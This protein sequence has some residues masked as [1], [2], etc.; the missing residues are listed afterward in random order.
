MGGRVRP[1]RHPDPLKADNQKNMSKKNDIIDKLNAAKIEFDPEASVKELEA[2]LPSDSEESTTET[3]GDIE[4][5]DPMLLRPR[6]LPLVVKPAD[7]GEWK[8]PEQA[9]YARYLNA[10]AYKNP[11]KW[12]L[13]KKDRTQGNVIIKGLISKLAEIGEDPEKLNFYRGGEGGGIGFKNHLFEA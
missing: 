13:K 10:Y 7:G 3:I 2:L 4:V 5:G 11:K 12:A 6:E 9:E 8:N 1:R